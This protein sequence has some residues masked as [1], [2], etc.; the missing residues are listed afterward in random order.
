M[1]KPHLTLV[2]T[3][4]GPVGLGGKSSRAPPRGG[5][6]CKLNLVGVAPRRGRSA[7]RKFSLRQLFREL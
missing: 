5:A 4:P 3:I 1:V 7:T 2:R 6:V